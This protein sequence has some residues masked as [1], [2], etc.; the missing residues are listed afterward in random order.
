[1]ISGGDGPGATEQSVEVI[2][3]DGSTCTMPNLP[4][5]GRS[6]HSASGLTL[7]GGV[8]GAVSQRCSTF[9]GGWETSHY[10]SK[11][12]FG[13]ESW[14]SPNGIYIIGGGGTE[15]LSNTSSNTSPGF[16]LSNDTRYTESLKIFRTKHIFFKICLWNKAGRQ[17]CDDWGQMV[18]CPGS[19]PG[20]RCPRSSG[21]A[22]KLEDTPILSWLWLLLKK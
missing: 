11:D 22:P 21:A 19:C 9:N 18:W 8:A 1:M 12:R 2:L 6:H 4:P 14:L 5:P 13:S 17:D 3:E 10:L 20:L 16:G 7:C 15:L